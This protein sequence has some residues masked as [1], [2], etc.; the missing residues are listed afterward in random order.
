MREL[1]PNTDADVAKGAGVAAAIRGEK[2][3][4]PASTE[5]VSAAAGPGA[6]R[7]AATVVAARVGRTGCTRFGSR[8]DTRFLQRGSAITRV[9]W[10]GE[11]VTLRRATCSARGE[12]AR[13]SKRRRIV[14]S[15]TRISI[16][17]NAAPR[18][19]RTPPPYGIH[20]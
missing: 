6:R 3:A 11:K 16:S 14:P 9:P 20:V 1:R 7:D 2:A 8:A 5:G 15:T 19:R 13:S 17:A 18:Q 10:R 4:A 12:P